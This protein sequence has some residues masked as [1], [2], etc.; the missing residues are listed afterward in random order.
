ML[1]GSIGARRSAASVSFVC[2]R[3]NEDGGCTQQFPGTDLGPEFLGEYHAGRA[4][5]GHGAPSSPLSRTAAM[6]RT[7][8]GLP[9]APES[10]VI[11][12]PSSRI[13]RVTAP[14]VSFR[15]C[16]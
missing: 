8:F 14:C 4:R 15:P 9:P 7:S 1:N 6:T 10:C 13:A 2:S 11:F 5:E 16:V 12:P 3:K